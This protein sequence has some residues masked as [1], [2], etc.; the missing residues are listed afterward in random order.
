LRAKRVPPAPAG[1]AAVD[2]AR[3][4]VARVP[5]PEADCCARIAA[6][7]DCDRTTARDWLAVLRALGLVERTADGYRRTGDDPSR[8][9]LRD[10]LLDGVYGAR[11]ALAAVDDGARTPAAV[12]ARVP[13]PTWESHRTP[14]PEGAWERHAGHLLGW[15]ALVGAVERD[16]DGA[17]RPA[18]GAAA[19]GSA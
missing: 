16:G 3:G 6:A 9:T 18:D 11:E 15:L 12:A 2:A 10:R 14:D 1:L 8:A 5:D 7:V 13:Q 19:E 4:A 17:Y